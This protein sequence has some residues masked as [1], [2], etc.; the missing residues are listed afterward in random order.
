MCIRDRFWVQVANPESCT[1]KGVVPTVIPVQKT[2]QLLV[3]TSSAGSGELS[4]KADSADS[5]NCLDCKILVDPSDPNVQIV[6]MSGLECGQCTF[7]LQWAGFDIPKMP[8]D[9]T[10]V[11]PTKCSFTCDQ[12]KSGLVKTTDKI[13]LIVNTYEG[14]NCPPEV[15]ASGPKAKYAVDVEKTGEG[16]YTASFTPWQEGAQKVQ[17]FIGGVQLNDSPITFEA[18]KPLDSGKITVAGDGLKQAI[19]NRR[20]EVTISAGEPKIFDRGLLK[21]AF[22]WSESDGDREHV[23]MDIIDHLNGTYKVS[24][25][26]LKPGKL[27]MRVTSE[28]SNINGSPFNVDAVSYTHLTLPT[29]YS[30]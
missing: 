14:G 6:K 26:P 19:A 2:V 8:V 10:V 12:V 11:D 25:M 28:G 27:Q 3:D 13:S 30:V 18:F 1:A 29:I 22:E 21:V 17:V 23:E 15:I 20:N 24:Y 7:Q 9:V 4:F 5:Q 16:E